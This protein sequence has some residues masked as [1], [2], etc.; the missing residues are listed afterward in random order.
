M[1]PIFNSIWNIAPVGI[2]VLLYFVYVNLIAK[3]NKAL[4]AL[5]GIDTQ[6]EMRHNLIPNILTIA[7]RYMK[8]ED[9]MLTKVTELRTRAMSSYDKSNP[10]AVSEH[11]DL[12]SQLTGQMGKLQVSVEAYPELKADTQ[13]TEAMRNYNE[14]ESRISAARRTYNAAVT[15]LNNAVQIFPSSVFARMLKI[16]AMPYFEASEAS[17]A[18]VNASD[19]LN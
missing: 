15:A 4:E 11:L 10:A 8:H 14:V 17:R 2:L 18:P 13:M 3:R 1:E 16:S 6:L 7:K 5:S 9:D 19:Y 12:A